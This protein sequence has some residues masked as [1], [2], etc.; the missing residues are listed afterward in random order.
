MLITATS[1]NALPFI[2][3]VEQ[4][5]VENCRALRFCL[6]KYDKSA[7]HDELFAHFDL[8]FPTQVASAVVK[9]RA[10]HLAGRYAARSLLLASGCNEHVAIGSDGVPQWP[11]GW[12]GSISH[13]A[14]WAIAVV[15]PRSAGLI[16]GIDIEYLAPQTMR[17]TADLFVTSAE[18]AL[19]AGCDIENETALLIL[20][21]AK[22]SLYKSLY[23][24]VQRFFGFEA[25]EICQL[26]VY[27]Q[28]FTLRLTETLTPEFP[29]GFCLSGYYQ[30]EGDR[31]MTL[32]F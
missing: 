18:R 1:F 21:S 17:E 15:A 7:Y 28:T 23:P 12:V 11:M 9:R 32:V 16:P 27:Q 4:G 25:A 5:T 14:Q 10:E 2:H 19:L 8:P 3:H 26:D 31:V 6:V 29:A 30:I 13:T 22:E 24:K 20:F